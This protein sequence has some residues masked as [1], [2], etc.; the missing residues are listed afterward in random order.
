M[1]PTLQPSGC[2]KSRPSFPL[3]VD[4]L[5]EKGHAPIELDLAPEAGNFE[6]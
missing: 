1:S 3:P 5:A 4:G 6:A 2:Y